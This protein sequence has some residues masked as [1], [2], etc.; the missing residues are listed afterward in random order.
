MIMALNI[1]YMTAG[2]PRGGDERERER[3]GE[4]NVGSSSGSSLLS[5]AWSVSRGAT[6]A[7]AFH[8]G[9]DSKLTNKR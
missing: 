2:G 1:Y 3:A 5:D 7:R 6:T 9:A 8:R 4:R